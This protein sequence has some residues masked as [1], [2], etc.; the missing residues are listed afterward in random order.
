MILPP[1]AAFLAQELLNLGA[2]PWARIKFSPFYFPNGVNGEGSFSHTAF[3]SPDR[4]QGD[5]EAFTSGYW[6]SETLECQ[7]GSYP[8]DAIITWI[9][10]NPGFDLTFYWRTAATMAALA[11]ASYETLTNGQIIEILQFYQFKLV[12]AGKRC[13]GLAPGGTPGPLTVYGMAGA[14]DEYV[15]YAVTQA[16]SGDLRTYIEALELIGEYL[17]ADRDVE[18][19]GT[20]TVEAPSAFDDLVAGAHSGLSL[21]NR[22]RNA[23]GEY[24]PLFNPNKASFIFGNEKDALGRPSWYGKK[25]E[26]E[27]GYILPDGSFE[28]VTVWQGKIIKW[29]PPRHGAEQ[30]GKMLPHNCDIYARDWISDLF[31]TKL[32]WP[33]EDGSPHPIT[34]GEF[35]R[36]AE[37][38]SGWSPAP[39]IKSASF[40]Q[41]N[42]NE[43]DD[44]VAGGGGQISIISPGLKG[45]YAFRAQVSGAN[46][47]A[48]GMLSLPLAGEIH[49]K[50]NLRFTAMPGTF[51]NQ[52]LTFLRLISSS[53]TNVASIMVDNEGKI[54]SGDA[55]QGKFAIAAYAGVNIPFIIWMDGSRLKL[56]LNGDEILNYKGSMSLAKNILFGALTVG[57]AESWTIDFDNI[58]LRNKYYN[59]SFR[60]TGAPFTDIGPVYLDNVAQ[61]D[62]QIIGGFTQ[63]V[64]RHPQYGL[65]Q[66]AST[67]PDFSPPSDVLI[68][69]IQD[70][71]GLHA[72]DLL[73]YLIGLAGA[74]EYVDAVSLAAAKAA[75]P[76]DI[77]HFRKGDDGPFPVADAIKD[78]CS[79]CLYWLM[80]DHGQIKLFAYDGLAPAG[81]T[82]SRNWINS[83]DLGANLLLD[84]D[85]EAAGVGDWPGI[86]SP[87]TLEKS[88]DQKYEGAQS[89]HVIAGGGAGA[90]QTFA[91][92]TGKLYKAIIRGYCIS[93]KL[94]GQINI[95]G[96][97]ILLLN[98]AGLGTWYAGA[99]INFESAGASRWIRLLGTGASEI[100][101]DLAEMREVDFASCFDLEAHSLANNIY[102]KVPVLNDPS[103]G[104]ALVGTRGGAAIM[105]S[106]KANGLI[107]YLK[108]KQ[109]ETNCYIALD[110][111][112]A[113]VRSVLISDTLVTYDAEAQPGVLLAAGMARLMYGDKQV[114]GDQT[115]TESAILQ[116]GYA[117]RFSVSPDIEMGP[118]TIMSGADFR[119]AVLGTVT[120]AAGEYSAFPDQ[121]QLPSGNYLCVYRQGSDHQASNDGVIKSRLSSDGQTWEAA[122]TVYTPAAGHDARGLGIRLLTS[123][124]NAGKILLAFFETW[125][126][127]ANSVVKTMIGSIG[128]GDAITWESPVTAADDNDSISSDSRPLELADGTIVLPVYLWAG[129]GQGAGLVKSSDGG[130]SWGNYI[131]V[132]LNTSTLSFS[133]P[134][135]ILEPSGRLVLF[136]RGDSSNAD[137]RGIYRSHSD[138][139]GGLNTWTAEEL[140]LSMTSNGRPNMLRLASGLYFMDNRDAGM[141]IYSR[142]RTGG[143]SWT[144]KHKFVNLSNPA[145]TGA[146]SGAIQL[147][148]GD[149]AIVI[150]QEVSSTRAKI[151]FLTIIND[152]AWDDYFRHPL[153]DSNIASV[154]PVTDLDEIMAYISA[155]YGWYD[156]DPGLSYLA[157]DQETGE[158]QELD[159]TWS[160]PVACEN[161]SAVKANADLLLLFLSMKELWDPV[162]TSYKG[163]RLEL[164][165]IVSIDSLPV[166]DRVLHSRVTRK[167]V[168]LDRG[169]SP[170][171]QVTLQFSRYQ[172]ET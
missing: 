69:V 89:L 85:M 1:S 70:P 8:A 97:A 45:N 147:P 90:Y 34:R 66:F 119:E 113:G 25:L 41:G 13:W 53:G 145:L 146:Y 81:G 159:Y 60:V 37:A 2:K 18:K 78:I 140:V 131:Q 168:N 154:E 68:R 169:D 130:A 56:W 142:S 150:A 33:D 117:G 7:V 27:F 28:G 129:S 64:T 49:A 87:T 77:I 95:G 98:N 134:N 124:P 51:A 52:N 72:V 61:A 20:L 38:V 163:A 144:E 39:L 160:S 35:L 31:K 137:E 22:Q 67:D 23:A 91:T 50:G 55:G 40:E 24:A 155:K 138:Y 133:E 80:V 143:V 19:F 57:T 105:D 114:G 99:S 153:T 3:I 122:Q 151:S 83:P 76:L 92:A 167:E 84:A 127:Q 166:A 102:V 104:G 116:A 100:F 36:K 29:G 21:N 123:G 48:Y 43:L 141:P 30:S 109:G 108:W 126:N 164:F 103:L 74:T 152:A 54:Y 94:N 128:E 132:L 107:A 86:G 121:A 46:Q 59:N 165:D 136:C 88:T 65:V 58:E 156:R 42:F 9:Q 16:V 162:L 101:W 112:V 148:N 135:A 14:P 120:D 125:N 96:S 10:N 71:G 158:G 93:G 63:T 62:S 11:A 111:F 171:E 5:Y 26:L 139:Q 6:E 170:L 115:I 75:K 106:T 73:E 79:R 12:L 15:S 82:W 47:S 17:V 44:V 157:G 4:I 149:I 161:Y 172:G 32:A 118:A 110:K